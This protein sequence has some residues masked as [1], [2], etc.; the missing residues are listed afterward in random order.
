[1]RNWFFGSLIKK[2]WLSSF[3]CFLNNL[4]TQGKVQFWVSSA[5][6]IW[7]VFRVQL[8]WVNSSRTDLVV[9]WCFCAKLSWYCVNFWWGCWMLWGLV[10][11]EFSHVFSSC[12]NT[13]DDSSTVDL[14]IRQKAWSGI[15]LFGITGY[16]SW[17]I[18]W[19][20]LYFISWIWH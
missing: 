8:Q 3:W 11:W 14:P 18:V 9:D 15:K 1:M 16:S 13:A 6:R 12:L 4:R 19:L 20:P 17:V 5:A 7:A 2:L 10:L